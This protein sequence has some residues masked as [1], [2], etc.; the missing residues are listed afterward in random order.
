MASIMD[1][2]V[3][4]KKIK[5]IKNLHVANVVSLII[6]A[7]LVS[8]YYYLSTPIVNSKKIIKLRE[9]QLQ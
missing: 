6:I 3:S 9:Q 8:I 4:V 1:V 5:S 7:L 2:R